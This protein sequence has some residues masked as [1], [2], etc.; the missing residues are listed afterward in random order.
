MSSTVFLILLVASIAVLMLLIMK[1]KLHPVFA[2]FVVALCMGL[3]IGQFDEGF[4]F[5]EVLKLITGG[6]GNTLASMGVPIMLGAVLAMAVQDTGAAK[7]I[8]NFFIRLFRGKNLELAPSLTAYVVSIPVFG[9]I[10]TILT[11]NIANVLSKRKHISMGKMAAFTQTGLNLTH[12]MV[13]PTPGIL[14]VTL[15]LG[16]DL[17][18]VIGWGIII[19]LI[20]FVLTWLILRKWTDKEFIEP[21]PEVVADIEETQSNDVKDILITDSDLP[22]TL[23]SFMTILIPV[24]LI[25]GSSFLKMFVAEGSAAYNVANIL[26]DKIVALGLGVIYTMLLALFHKQ[27][28]RKSNLDVTGKDPAPFREVLL[29]SW[30]ARGLE[31]ALS[32][33]LIT[34]MGGAFATVIKSAPAIEGLAAMIEQ[35]G[36]P[37]LLIPFLIGAIMFTA[38]GSMTTGGMTAAGVVG[39]MMLALGLSP[40]STVLAIGAGTMIFNHVN[41]SGFWVISRFFN[42]D[43]KQGLKYITIPDFVAGILAFALVCVCAAVGAI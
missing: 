37:G 30:I 23:A 31:I 14:A 41:N 9:D 7:S 3:V 17:G 19:S 10:T 12:A 26:G 39:P 24:V 33:L 28:V 27:S 22:G 25:A 20:A 34:G 29:N 15:L 32:A 36:V 13:P 18:L 16:A 2:L 4:S 6:F 5:P 21:V 8:A 11:S 43:L 42:L 38:V 40:V 1:A 35:S